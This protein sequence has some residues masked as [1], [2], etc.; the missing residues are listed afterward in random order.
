MAAAS[1]A[2]SQLGHGNFR[3]LGPQ[4]NADAR[5]V[6]GLL[7]ISGQPDAL[8]GTQQIDQSF[9]IFR[10]AAYPGL[11]LIRQAKSANPAVVIWYWKD[12][13]SVLTAT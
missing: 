8:N 4:G 5:I 3:Y 11:G 1:K 13:V 2:G 12:P 7:Q 9:R 10:A 6:L